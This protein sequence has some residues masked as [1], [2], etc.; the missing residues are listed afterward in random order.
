MPTDKSRSRWQG[1]LIDIDLSMYK[2]YNTY[3]C[4]PVGDVEDWME[5][6]VIG[7]LALFGL[8]TFSTMI[9][10][11]AEGV[12]FQIFWTILLYAG[13]VPMLWDLPVYAPSVDDLL[14]FIVPVVPLLV[15]T[16]LMGM[17]R[18]RFGEA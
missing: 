14:R 1:M 17:A 8:L 16:M 18:R 12:I 3:K 15:M 9:R 11:G 6:L 7:W 4:H 5:F 10:R 2:C 13:L